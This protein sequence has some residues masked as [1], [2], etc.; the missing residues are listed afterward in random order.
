M[1]PSAEIISQV[2]RVVA[3]TNLVK[4]H[5]LIMYL[6]TRRG[7]AFAAIALVYSAYALKFHTPPFFGG[8]AAH[9]WQLGTTFFASGQFNL[10]DGE[11]TFRGYL[12]PVIFG[13]LGQAGM[14]T[15]LGEFRLFFLVNGLLTA[16]SLAIVIPWLFQRLCGLR[17]SNVQLIFFASFFFFFWRGYLVEP[18]A[19]TWSLFVMLTA[20]A[21]VIGEK[22]HTG[23]K[24]AVYL[25]LAGILL[26]AAVNMRPIYLICA[27]LLFGGALVYN[28][29]NR[30]RVVIGARGG[31]IAALSA[32]FVLILLPQAIINQHFLS[33][34][35]PFIHTGGL[36]TH[37]L[38]FGISVSRHECAYFI[39]GAGVKLLSKSGYDFLK[40]AAEGKY[41]FAINLDQISLAEY[42]R[43]FVSNPVDVLSIYVRHVANGIGLLG[44]NIYH[45]Q[46]LAPRLSF[47]LLSVVVAWIGVATIS[48]MG[49]VA[50]LRRHWLV[51]AIP[52]VPMLFTVPTAM[53]GR[54]FLV[55]HLSA[56]AAISFF[57]FTGAGLARARSHT[58]F[59]SA[60][61]LAGAIATVTLLSDTFAS[62]YLWLGADSAGVSLRPETVLMRP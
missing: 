16:A 2:G 22:A 49:V 21:L 8:D 56:Y 35:N 25:F 6:S 3:C 26:G 9:Y 14:R 59:F 36:Y 15:N 11:G 40:P 18:L 31:Q 47:I 52:F 12:L 28:F 54:F 51:L 27:P 37:Q 17:P 39:D 34:W 58:L 1:K 19:D 24:R 48:L 13:Y 55:A 5:G 50:P 29:L 7:Y 4:E 60:I 33:T 45:C 62:T 23:R 61:A 20:I 30:K 10:L 32:G 57:L 38:F 42:A 43:I 53:E 44:S 41:L 46:P